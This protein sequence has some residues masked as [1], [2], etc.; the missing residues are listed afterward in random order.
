[1]APFDDTYRM[2]IENQKHGF[3]FVSTS[4]YNMSG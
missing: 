2:H 1:M 4:V 3:Y